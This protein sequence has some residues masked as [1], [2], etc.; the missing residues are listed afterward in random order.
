[1]SLRWDSRTQTQSWMNADDGLQ[2]A[3]DGHRGF[4][5]H[6]V[7]IGHV[8]QN[9]ILRVN[10]IRDLNSPLHVGGVSVN[11]NGFERGDDQRLP[12][13]GGVLF[14]LNHNGEGKRVFEIESGAARSRLQAVQRFRGGVALFRGLAAI[15]RNDLE[16]L[17]ADLAG[18]GHQTKRI[19]YPCV[20]CESQELDQYADHGGLCVCPICGCTVD[21]EME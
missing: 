17:S 2:V 5:S 8:L 3:N 14:D 12:P 11:R 18:S 1:M 13:A 16:Q 9:H 7:V 4:M 10:T 21:P 15:L 20:M 19:V 6:F